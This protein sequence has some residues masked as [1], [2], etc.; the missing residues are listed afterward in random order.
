M[1]STN[2]SRPH[3]GYGKRRAAA[4]LRVDNEVRTER[5]FNHQRH[6]VGVDG[7]ASLRCAHT[8]THVLYVSRSS[9]V[10]NISR[11]GEYDI[12][13]QSMPERI[14]HRLRIDDHEDLVVK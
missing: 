8:H 3:S 1:S 10:H 13:T 12:L 5:V 2:N 7:H 6:A 4:A 11:H 14:M 9:S